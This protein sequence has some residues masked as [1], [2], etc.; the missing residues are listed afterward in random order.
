[1][2]DEKLIEIAKNNQT[3][4]DSKEIDIDFVNLTRKLMHST[5]I[6]YFNWKKRTVLLKRIGW[7]SNTADEVMNIV[8]RGLAQMKYDTKSDVDINLLKFFR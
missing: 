1:M 7:K 4:L 8:E 2:T 3:I 6:E 5:A